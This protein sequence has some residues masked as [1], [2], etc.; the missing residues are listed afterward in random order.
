MKALVRS[1]AIAGA[2]LV[3]AGVQNA[4]AQVIYPVEFTTSFPFSVGNTVV[5]AGSYT[6]RPDD[7]NAKVLELQG[8]HSSVLFQAENTQAPETPSKS[9]VVFMRYGDG[10]VLKDIWVEGS[11]EGAEALTAEAEQHAAKRHGMDGE[12]R[13]A[14]RKKVDSSKNR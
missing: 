2:I 5:P 6:I 9:E 7:D 1:L 13:V 3:F 4:S 10:Y 11:N 14:A 12:Q 8:P